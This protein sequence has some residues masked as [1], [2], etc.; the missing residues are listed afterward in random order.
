VAPSD[1]ELLLVD[2]DNLL[3]EARGRRDDG[4][5]G[6]LLPELARWRPVGMR[7]VVA[8][9]GHP[10]PGEP[11]RGRAARGLEHHY[12]GSRPA[13]DVLIDLLSAQ[14][15]VRRGRSAVVSEDLALKQRARRAGGMALGVDWLL[16]QLSRGR[17]SGGGAAS[18]AGR[19]GRSRMKGADTTQDGPADEGGDRATWRPG[20]GAT[21]KRGNPRRA[22]RRSHRG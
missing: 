7:V 1:I 11:S 6:W 16:V 22:A 13:D 19:I 9:D 18:A 8:F 14:P 21:R 2:G 3:H 10:A 20:R 15:F 17:A 12:A 4:G 5:M